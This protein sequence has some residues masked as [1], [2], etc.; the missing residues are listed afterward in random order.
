MRFSLNAFRTSRDV[1]REFPAGTAF[2]LERHV[3][4]GKVREMH[5]I[6]VI[7][8]RIQ[9]DSRQVK[10]IAIDIVSRRDHRGCLWPDLFVS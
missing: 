2:S 9:N 3:T 1:L 5:D 6:N 8:M 10:D 7:P 4:R